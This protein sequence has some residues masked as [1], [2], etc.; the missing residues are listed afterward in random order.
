[1]TDNG[2]TVKK[3]ILRCAMQWL[4]ERPLPL[5]LALTSTKEHADPKKK[6]YL[7]L[8]YYVIMI[9]KLIKT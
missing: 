1:M 9:Q 6:L 2:L 7:V 4:S 5:R 8:R 3:I